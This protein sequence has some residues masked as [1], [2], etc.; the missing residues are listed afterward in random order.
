MSPKKTDL[1]SS[2]THRYDFDPAG[3][4]VGEEDLCSPLDDIDQLVDALTTPLAVP[5]CLIQEQRLEEFLPQLPGPQ[6]RH[7][8]LWKPRKASKEGEGSVVTL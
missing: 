6:H 7:S 5:V 3:I 1:S 4:D 2:H 8:L